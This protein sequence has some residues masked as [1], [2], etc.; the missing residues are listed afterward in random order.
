MNLTAVPHTLN[1]E[2]PAAAFAI[3]TDGWMQLVPLGRINAPLELER[4]GKIEEVQII[5]EVTASTV[6]RLADAFAAQAA[7]PNFPG[8]LVDF[9][10]FS[11]DTDKS[12]RAA[13]WI[14]EV[15]ARA[16][17]L[18]GRVRFSASGKAAVEGGDYRL[19]SPVLGFTPRAYQAGEIVEPSVLLRGA[20]TNDPR[21]KGMIPV[22]NRQTPFPS[23]PMKK[24]LVI[25]LLA[26]LGQTVAA[27]AAPEAFDAALTSAITTAEANKTEM[28]STASRLTTLEGQLV[29]S[30]LDKSGLQGEARTA[31][32]AVLTKNRAEGL[33]L[34][35]ALAKPDSG[36][37]VTHNRTRA[38]P[39]NADKS[40][41]VAAQAA[42][43][44]AAKVSCRA[45]EIRAAKPGITLADSYATAEAE[46]ATTK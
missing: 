32:K 18:W 16:D 34:I 10:H 7:K 15:A 40:A 28:A 4:S 30:D 20:L 12:S 25:Q 6:N 9:D 37:A 44:H 33:A 17:G 41:D 46:L 38:T 2:T 39:P 1:R 19:F 45:R 11:N 13:A 43:V 3:P 36:Y 31:A 42:E 29:E 22:S 21:Y 35:A 24:E 23:T 27:D 8:L 5:Q 26:A 14:E